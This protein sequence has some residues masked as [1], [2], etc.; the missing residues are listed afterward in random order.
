M[1]AIIYI[2]CLTLAW[3]HPA[4]TLT[5]WSH[6]YLKLLRFE[7]FEVQTDQINLGKHTKALT[8]YPSAVIAFVKLAWFLFYVV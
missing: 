8:S 3:A 7:I 6:F 4:K 1:I 2:I 5:V